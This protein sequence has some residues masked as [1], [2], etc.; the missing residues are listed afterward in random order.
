MRLSLMILPILMATPLPS[1]AAK[2]L[3]IKSFPCP[4][5]SNTP[6]KAVFNRLGDLPRAEAFN[7]VLRSDTDCRGQLV[8]ARDRLGTVPKPRR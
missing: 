4:N 2:P 3:Q 7:A 8:Q 1:T 6:D 5:P